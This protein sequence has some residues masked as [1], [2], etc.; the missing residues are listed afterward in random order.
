[1]KVYLH[2]ETALLN[3]ES[4]SINIYFVLGLEFGGEVTEKFTISVKFSCKL[5]E[6]KKKWNEMIA[7]ILP[8]NPSHTKVHTYVLILLN[9]F[10]IDYS[11]FFKKNKTKTTTKKSN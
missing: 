8:K 11:R 3:T 7:L 10:L 6:K 5:Q 4:R 2:K 9:G 1:M